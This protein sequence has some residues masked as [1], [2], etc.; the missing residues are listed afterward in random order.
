ML[1]TRSVRASF[2]EDEQVVGLPRDAR[3]LLLGVWALADDEG[4]LVWDPALVAEQVFPGDADLSEE[5]AAGLM[6][7]IA[8]AG[9]VRVY[10]VG[11]RRFGAVTDWSRVQPV[12]RPRPSRLPRPPVGG[13]VLSDGP[14]MMAA[15]P[16]TTVVPADDKPT[17]RRVRAEK[18][19]SREED[20]MGL[21]DD[22]IDAFAPVAPVQK[23]EAQ[24]TLLDVP[25]GAVSAPVTGK[26]PVKRKPRK[27]KAAD[28]E[29]TVLYS[30]EVEALC[31]RLA[32]AARRNVAQ[33]VGENHAKRITVNDAWLD[34]ADK[35]LRLDG[36]TVEQIQALI[37]W[38]ADDQFWRT[39]IRSMG[40]LREKVDRLAMDQRFLTWARSKGR[41]TKAAANGAVMPVGPRGRTRAVDQHREASA[42]E[43]TGF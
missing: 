3:L 19:S 10:E 26:A 20:E 24:P 9:L 42:Y 33:F 30:P 35:M 5:A 21:Y 23:P 36:F 7:V 28:G 15:V 27:K 40:T 39:N 13:C 25:A 16:Q 12:S 34:A 2:W 31:E 1:R 37:D 8:A 29:Q 32:V 17:N 14:E 18:T 11:V 4:L 6:A 41:A 43:V 22:P 38:T